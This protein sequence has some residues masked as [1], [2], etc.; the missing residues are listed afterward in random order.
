[1]LDSSRAS[2]LPQVQHNPEDHGNPVGAGLPAKG[3][4]QAVALPGLYRM[5]LAWPAT[6]LRGA[7]QAGSARGAGAAIPL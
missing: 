1:M 7:S 6:P 5:L 4:V 2:P 3:P